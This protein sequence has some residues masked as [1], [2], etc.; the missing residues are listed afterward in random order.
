M[1]YDML[2]AKADGVRQRARLAL[3]SQATGPHAA[4]AH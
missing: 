4:H 3:Q 1:V 2:K